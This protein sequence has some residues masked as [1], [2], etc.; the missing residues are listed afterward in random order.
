MPIPVRV[1]TLDGKL[2]PA[3]FTAD[4]LDD[5]GN[6]E[7]EGVYTITRTYHSDHTVML[8][9]H[10]DRLEHS[11]LL[12]NIELKLDRDWIRSGLRRLIHQAGFKESRFRITIPR[13]AP[14]TAILAVEPL[15]IITEALRKSGVLV[16][17][18]CI[19]RPNP[20]A[21]ST[22]W[23][24]RRE[25]ARKKL[26]DWAYEG[27]VC[28]ADGLILEGFSSNFYSVESDRLRT[29][30]DV[31]LSGIARKILLEVSDGLVDVDYE[32][33]HR[34]ELDALDEALLTSSSRGI[35]PI[36][37]IDDHVIGAGQ[38]GPVTHELWQ[39]YQRWVEGH[40]EKL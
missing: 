13:E 6:F 4:S 14:D 27:L 36:V 21:K 22:R 29:A 33:I 19:E 37:G 8:D 2:I 38:P 26:P 39:R 34:N 10:M 17:T 25:M 35:V 12:E 24:Q 30:K 11:A 18:L 3:S 15:K 20:Q 31:V 16:A 5:V 28:T 9:A 23:I 7:P 32:P 1:L 40:L